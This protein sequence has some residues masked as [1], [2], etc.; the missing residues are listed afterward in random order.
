LVGQE[1]A[2]FIAGLK[3]GELVDFVGG[4]VG[5]LEEICV[6]VEM[7]GIVDRGDWDKIREGKLVFH[8]TED[9]CFGEKVG[10][11]AVGY[12]EGKHV[13]I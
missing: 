13:G 5:L 7:D 8:G 12:F 1:E 2:C 9:G 10:F 4:E 6:D 3:D 11:R